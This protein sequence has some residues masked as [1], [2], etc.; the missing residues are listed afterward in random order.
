MSI[1][2]EQIR[3]VELNGANLRVEL[4]AGDYPCLSIEQIDSDEFGTIEK[5]DR[6]VG[7]SCPLSNEERLALIELLTL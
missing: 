1:E 6:L 7:L 5:G 3:R 4:T 2:I